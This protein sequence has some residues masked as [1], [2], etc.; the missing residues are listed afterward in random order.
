MTHQYKGHVRGR[1]G[2]AQ[3]LSWPADPFRAGPFLTHSYVSLG[4][5]LR[6]S[7]I[8]VTS[9]REYARTFSPTR[10]G[11]SRPRPVPG[12]GDHPCRRGGCDGRDRDPDCVGVPRDAQSHPDPGS[13][14]CLCRGFD[15]R[16]FGGN[17]P[18]DDSE[19]N[20]HDGARPSPHHG[21]TPRAVPAHDSS[22]RAGQGG[23]PA[24]DPR[25]HRADV[26]SP[27]PSP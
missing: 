17:D 25:R 27:V 13:A 3:P 15:A 23:E 8:L 14:G 4:P 5:T 20:P 2:P 26:S 19:H 10:S 18:S 22:V 11:Q 6:C 16:R 1:R 9:T 21:D 7:A 12:E 24:T